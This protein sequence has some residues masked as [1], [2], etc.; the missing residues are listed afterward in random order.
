MAVL[1][2][3]KLEIIIS[4]L[5]HF[6][7]CHTLVLVH[8]FCHSVS[9]VLIYTACFPRLLYVIRHWYK[10]SYWPNRAWFR[11]PVHVYWEDGLDWGIIVSYRILMLVVTMV[12]WKSY[13]FCNQEKWNTSAVLI[14]IF[15]IICYTGMFNVQ[16]WYCHTETNICKW[17][18]MLW[19]KAVFVFIWK[20]N[21]S[22][23]SSDL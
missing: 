13:R 18:T 16:F 2:D 22:T 4:S 1:C 9:H 11:D 12:F 14:A 8:C 7:L 10:V 6:F 21:Q 3:K 5:K 17:G 19:F 15:W 23:V 20:K